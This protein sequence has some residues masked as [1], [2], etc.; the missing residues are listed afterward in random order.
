MFDKNRASKVLKELLIKNDGWFEGHTIFR[1]GYHSD[2]WIEKGALIRKP[3]DLEVI[4]KLQA[5]QIAEIFGTL[6]LIVGTPNCGAIVASYVAR[7]LGAELAITDDA[8]DELEF[9]RMYKPQSGLKA[10][11]VDDLINT[12]TDMRDHIRFFREYGIDLL[13]VSVW[14]N[15]QPDT[16]LGLKVL[17]LMPAPFELFD[18]DCSSPCAS[19]EPIKYE[20]IRE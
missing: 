14:I 2:G 16:L 7:H 20:N 8:K 9:H 17:T 18:A 3:Q 13:G 4:C 6:P 11:L 5:E 15:R 12:G 19:N 1:N 10:V